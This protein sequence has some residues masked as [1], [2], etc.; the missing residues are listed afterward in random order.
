MGIDFISKAA[1]SF[2]KGWISRV[3]N[4]VRRTLPG[5]RIS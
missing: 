3:S 4:L 1:K 5:Q 2:H